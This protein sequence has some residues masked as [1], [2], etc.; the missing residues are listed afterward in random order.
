MPVETPSF[1]ADVVDEFLL[2]IGIQDI[3]ELHEVINQLLAWIP[4]ICCFLSWVAMAFTSGRSALR[5][6]SISDIRLR[7]K[8][9]GTRVHS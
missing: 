9:K 7:K 1:F 3:V 4:L 8:H 5:S 6:F 2:L